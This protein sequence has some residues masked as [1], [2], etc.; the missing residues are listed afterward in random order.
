METVAV[1]GRG[2]RPLLQRTMKQNEGA[3]ENSRDRGS[4]P[5]EQDS[6]KED[7]EDPTVV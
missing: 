3:F 7:I 5:F 4:L 2:E 6:P 1:D